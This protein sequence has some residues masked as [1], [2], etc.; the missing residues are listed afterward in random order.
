MSFNKGPKK[1]REPLTESALFDYA[2]ASLGRSAQTVAELK[3]KLR[4]R[5]EPGETGEQK[6]GAVVAKLKEYRFLNDASFAADYTRLR[7]EN[8]KFGR[9]R[10]QQ[11]LMQKGVH[12]E[13][14][15]KALD[16]AYESVN[17]EELARAYIARKRMAQ[18]KDKKD[19]ARTMRRLIAAG[20]T[21]PT[22][23]KVLRTWVPDEEALDGIESV[24]PSDE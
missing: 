19:A 2:T 24:E 12:T 20:F 6:I 13:L 5:V 4:T 18:P 8:E 14:A 23:F 3:R 1:E 9:R 10:V 11:G 17:E 21:P 15:T 7:Q 16:T 22:V